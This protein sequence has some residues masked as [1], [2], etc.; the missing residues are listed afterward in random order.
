MRIAHISDL[1]LGKTLHGF[2]LLDD[3]DFILKQIVQIL[4]EKEVQVLLICGD[5]FDKNIAPE[6]GIKIF[7]NFLNALVCENIKVL[8]ISGNH[9]SAE[10]LTFG[11][12]F[13]T[14]KGIYFSKVYDGD[15]QKV[16]L[17]DHYGPVNF[18]L[19]PFIKPSTVKHFYENEEIES[20]EDA[21]SF[22]IKKL[23]VNTKERNILLAHQNILNAEHCDSEEVV[24]GGLDAIGT[25]VFKDFDY[26]ALGHI[27]KPQIIK[28][29][30]IFCGTPLKYSSS[31]LNHIKSMP[32]IDL[33]EKG[34]LK[35]D[36]I[37][38]KPMR[39][40]RQI[41]GTFD[42]IMKMAKKDPNNKE[43]F[44]DIILTDENEV[45]DA[46]TSLRTEYPNIIKITYDNKASKASEENLVFENINQTNPLNTFE[47]FFEGRR[48]VKMTDEQRKIIKDLIEEIWEAD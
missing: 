37:P 42:Q 19:L 9:D 14:E 5:V 44:I 39:D 2:S 6:A 15:I 28:D 18:Y 10:R 27:H 20:Y 1:H 8:I 29:N 40:L 33:Q 12:E 11:A 35:L 21:L 47:D 31:E 45:L 4:K 16:T 22:I 25:E 48:G 41:T 38:L 26:T 17:P 43:D 24:I 34:S 32:V 36:F 30:I 46:I 3:Q 13:M 7:R 23:N